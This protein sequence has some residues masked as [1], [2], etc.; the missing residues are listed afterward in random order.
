MLD[1]LGDVGRSLDATIGSMVGPTPH[2][3]SPPSNRWRFR[4]VADAPRLRCASLPHAFLALLPIHPIR[5]IC[6]P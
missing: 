3:A 1:F 5:D 6:F 4:Y 2:P